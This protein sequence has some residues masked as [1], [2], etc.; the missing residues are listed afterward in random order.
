MLMASLSRSLLL[1]PIPFSL[2]LHFSCFIFS[3]KPPDRLSAHFPSSPSVLFIS[4][5]YNVASSL[6]SVVLLD[7]FLRNKFLV[8]YS[9]NVRQSLR[10][11]ARLCFPSLFAF[12][13]RRSAVC[14]ECLRSLFATAPRCLSPSLTRPSPSPLALPF[15]LLFGVQG[16]IPFN[17]LRR[18]AQARQ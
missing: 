15:R 12:S 16:T 13:P 3:R 8:Q 9:R 10:R 18:C 17:S 4:S 1:L 6:S 7:D 11:N 5:V 14:A 2:S